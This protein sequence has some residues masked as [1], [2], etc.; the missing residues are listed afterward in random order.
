VAASD[1]E[2]LLSKNNFPFKNVQMMACSEAQKI[3][4]IN[5]STGFNSEMKPQEKDGG[6]RYFSFDPDY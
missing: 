3:F 6:K 5:P 2:S 1:I 4:G